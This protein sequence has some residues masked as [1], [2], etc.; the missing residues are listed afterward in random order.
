MQVPGFRF[1]GAGFRKG[2]IWSLDFI[3]GITLM[4]LLIMLF[5]LEWNYL[6]LRW[7]TSATYREMLTGALY[8]SEALFTTS[9]DPA[10]W[11]KLP[12]PDD[13]NIVSFGLVNGRNE[14]SNLKIARLMDLN[15]SD[16]NYT[17]VADRLGLAGYQL[18]LQITDL[19]GNLTYYDFG[20]PSG[21]NNSAVL[22][23]FVLINDSI[24]AKAR[25]EVWK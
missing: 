8:A 12:A 13:S 16:A 17:L 14:L 15:A 11:E 25:V 6:S 5:I 9:G 19:E 3:S 21:L 20:R 1:S 10:G 24:P 4:S 23:R 7:N 18:R 2:Q 22:E